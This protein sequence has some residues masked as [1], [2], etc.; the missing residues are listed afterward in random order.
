MRHAE[1]E[2]MLAL[3]YLLLINSVNKHRMPN[4]WTAKK[5]GWTSPMTSLNFQTLSSLALNL[6]VFDAAMLDGSPSVSDGAF[7]GGS[8]SGN[9]HN[10][11][12]A[13]TGD[14]SLDKRP[15]KKTKKGGDTNK[16]F[17]KLKKMSFANRMKTVLRWADKCGIQRLP[18]DED[19]YDD[20]YV[21]KEG[22]DLICCE[23]C[24]QSLHPECL[25]VEGGGQGI[26]FD[27]IDFV[28]EQCQLDTT[29]HYEGHMGG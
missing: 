8:N 16:Y 14:D 6:Y 2:R 26:N 13:T 3:A 21:C 11:S 4:W 7:L 23:F 27:D 29:C 22:G 12:A 17:E 15:P 24:R 28:C 1:N 9:S 5:S 25:V 19:H 18:A 10:E 20:C